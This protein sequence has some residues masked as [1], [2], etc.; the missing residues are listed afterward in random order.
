[1]PAKS[2]RRCQNHSVITPLFAAR[3]AFARPNSAASFFAF[4]PQKKE[5]R[6]WCIPSLVL[7]PLILLPALIRGICLYMR[8]CACACVCSKTKGQK[9]SSCAGFF[10][11]MWRRRNV[12]VSS[13]HFSPAQ[14]TN[15]D[16]DF[17]LFPLRFVSLCLSLRSDPGKEGRK[18][19]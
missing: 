3:L 8:L 19:T 10:W 6:R 2:C 17:S 18:E 11:Q 16:D 7:I 15:V 12:S 14:R 1:M 4:S 9:S 5:E 13:S